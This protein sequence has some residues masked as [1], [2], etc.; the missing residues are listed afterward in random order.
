MVILAV[1]WFF[2]VPRLPDVNSLRDYHLQTP[3]RVMSRDGKLISEF[4]EQR[5]IPLSIDQVPQLYIDALLSAEDENFYSHYGVDPK[6][7]LRAAVR[8][9]QAG[10]KIQGGGSTITM[11]VARNYLLTLDQTFIRKFNEILLSFQIEQELSK[12][13]IL[14]MYFNKM[15]M[16]HRAYGIEAASHVYYGRSISE[17]DLPQL[18]MLAGLYK[19]PSKYNP[20]SNP[21]RSKIRRDWILGRM[22][23]LNYIQQEQFEVAI[24]TPITARFHSL[25]PETSA[26]YVAEMVRSELFD[27]FPIEDVYTGGYRVYTTIDSKL[28]DAA[29][30]AV[31]TGLLAYD[32]RHGYRGVEKNHG[33]NVNV[34]DAE[35]LLNRTPVFG[36]LQPAIVRRVDEESAQLLL[37]YG[38]IIT[39]NFSDMSWVRPRLSINSLG[40]A[41]DNISQILRP[42][43]QVRVRQAEDDTNVWYLSQVPDAQGALI[44]LDPKD[45]AMI[46]LVGGFEYLHSKF[47]RATQALRQPGSNFKP[48]VYSAA[49][50]QDFTAATLINDAPVV[51]NDASLEGS[52]RPENYSGKFFGPT[53]LRKALYK[54]RNLVSI[55]IL[56][57]IGIKSAINYATRFG[58]K[59]QQL[60]RN[61]S[62]A[63]GSASV[64]PIDV[65]TAY[66]SFANQGYQVKPYFIER[67]EDS[68]GKV[69]YQAQPNTVCP[70][71]DYVRHTDEVDLGQSEDTQTTVINDVAIVALDQA[72]DQEDAQQN[73]EL[74]RPITHLPI[75]PRIMD[76]RVNY[77]M[78]TI[79]QDVVKKGTARKAKKLNRDD[80]AGK[81]GTTNDQK[82]AWFSGYVDAMV[83]TAW[84][85][86]DQPTTLGKNE[87]GSTAALPIWIDFMEI[88]L[89]DVPQTQ[90][91]QPDDMVTIKIDEATGEL[92]RPGD[93]SAVEEIFRAERTPKQMALPK[94]TGSDTSGKNQEAA[95][96]QVF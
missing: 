93:A 63:L 38:Q 54:S 16:G 23:K 32:R 25:K 72:L 88:A 4:G 91:Q 8:M 75:A 73:T 51:F 34:E 94:T 86:F 39:I 31:Q 70:N 42:G 89:K 61:L 84:V 53:R 6:A 14:E 41:P 66:A 79:L 56:R 81:T 65:A 44:A 83:A 20:I 27:A 48:I 74:A 1:T 92:A 43:D 24:E 52:W 85:G 12:K 13:Q 96:E 57:E 68:L 78:H 58:F 64:P 77:I 90:R 69:L 95:P 50:E 15:F 80:L 11:Q 62:L 22:L 17:L 2:L 71:C 19:A 7:L 49:L 3:L 59:P 26:S 40:R 10:G 46:A 29:Q 87:F 18:A 67:I 60:P 9:V 76:E 21:T 35:K 47:N 28:Q 82:D 45:G 30:L 33:P 37:R 5:R 36:P 55:R